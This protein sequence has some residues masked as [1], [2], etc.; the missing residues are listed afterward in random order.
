VAIAAAIAG[1]KVSPDFG[2][3][4]IVTTG[5]IGLGT[6]LPTTGSF[7]LAQGKAIVGLDS[8]GV[9]NV[10]ILDWGVSSPDTL[11]FGDDLFSN[12]LV[13]R[14]AGGGH[15]FWT[16]TVNALS[17]ASTIVQIGVVTLQFAATIS[18]PVSLHVN[19]NAPTNRAIRAQGAT[20]SNNNGGRM[21]VQGGIKNGTGLRRG[22]VLQLNVDDTEANMVNLL[23]VSEVISGNR[24]LS[25]LKPAHLTTAQMPASTGDMVAYLANCATAPTSGIPVGGGILY[26]SGGAL[27]W[28]DTNGTDSQVSQGGT[29]ITDA[30]QTINPG[31]ISDYQLATPTA[32]R[33]ITLGVAG[34]LFN[35]FV[36]RILTIDNAAFTVAFL[37]GGT[38]A[39]TMFTR[40]ASPGARKIRH[41]FRYNGVDHVY[42]GAEV[43]P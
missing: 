8:T 29:I 1:T 18:S 17:V 9:N 22:P 11:T 27:R 20:G 12:G 30:D 6:P 10:K 43:V 16:Q 7:R 38:N 28:K 13:F 4:N 39:A 5:F 19:G 37:N 33:S 23:E 42:L 21:L 34:A 2:S 32:N 26:A 35:G 25:L 31:T 15:N 41:V 14:A 40:A 24:V 3:Q 36:T